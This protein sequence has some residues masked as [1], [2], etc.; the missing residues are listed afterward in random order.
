[1]PRFAEFDLS[2]L[3]TLT[4]V[5]APMPV[6][7]MRKAIAK[8]GPRVAHTYTLS[9]SP[10]VTTMFPSADL[11]IA[12]ADFPHRVQSCGREAMDFRVAVIGKDGEPVA[13]GEV[14]EVVVQSACN[15]S[16]YWQRP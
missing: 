14:G 8:L 3:R 2:G 11:A 15:M 1:H 9:E 10:V 12:A 4:V 13:A 5:S 6:E 7:R 16:G